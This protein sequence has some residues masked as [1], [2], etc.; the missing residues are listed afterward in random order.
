MRADVVSGTVGGKGRR[1]LIVAGYLPPYAPFGTIRVPALAS[2][3]L[4]RGADV[5]IIA[6]KTDLFPN[7]ESAPIDPKRISYVDFGGAAPPPPLQGPQS[8]FKAWLGKVMPNLMARLQF[9]S[10][11]W[12]DF[13][14]VPDAFLPWV[15]NAVQHGV[16]WC[17]DWKPDFIYSSGPPQSSHLVAKSLK[18][19]FGCLWIAEMR[20]PWSN[21]PYTY[22]TSPVRWRNR[23]IEQATLQSA[24]AIV[25]LT[26]SEQQRYQ[27]S[28]QKPVIFVRNGFTRS[29]VQA[30]GMI[31]TASDDIVI[32]HA[33]ALYGGRRDPRG[34]LDAMRMLG[35]DVAKV[36]LKLVGDAET[37][38][39]M[40][41][42]YADL[43]SQVDIIPQISHDAVL[44]LYQSSDILLL[45]RWDDPRERSFVAG[46]IFEYIASRKPILCLGESQGEAADIIR[47][48]GFGFVTQSTEET[49]FALRGWLETK[50]RLGKI[51]MVPEAATLPFARDI[52]F[53]QLDRFIDSLGVPAH[54]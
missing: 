25:T 21:N 20:D 40:M 24:N 45:L 22:L 17:Q 54:T 33:G 26:R 34:L 39:L 48:N 42:D 29:Q 14:V 36:R 10:G 16:R 31:N 7:I 19:A 9:W 43:Q 30:V 41:L 2:Y 4:A 12:H 5:R 53:E 49:A 8:P 18:R 32:T 28:Y 13:W 11:Q 1:I 27:G 35:A 3:W 46:K 50:K 6:A 44:E 15:P 51:P 38:E 47:D 37:A 52:Q 23:R